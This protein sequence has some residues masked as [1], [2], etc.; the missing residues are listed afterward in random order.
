MYQQ[1]SSK[2]CQT[3]ATVVVADFFNLNPAGIRA[4]RTLRQVRIQ[5]GSRIAAQVYCWY[6]EHEIRETEAVN[7]S[8]STF[9]CRIV[10]RLN[11]MTTAGFS[12]LRIIF[13][14]SSEIGQG[15]RGTELRNTRNTL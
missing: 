14:Y 11:R 7:L 12:N 6:I 15:K 9:E 13:P 2:Y 4:P 8:V 10:M 3:V 1:S 5:K